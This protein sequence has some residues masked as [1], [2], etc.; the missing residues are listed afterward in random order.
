MNI[1]AN[2]HLLVCADENDAYSQHFTKGMSDFPQNPT[3]MLILV[4]VLVLKD[5]LR[6]KFKSLFLSWSL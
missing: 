3:V 5:S 6:T 4:I 2:V 1:G